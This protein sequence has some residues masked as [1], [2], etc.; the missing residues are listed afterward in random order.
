MVATTQRDSRCPIPFTHRL[1]LLFISVD[2]GVAG[3]AG[4]GVAGAGVAGVHCLQPQTLDWTSREG[5]EGP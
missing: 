2:P 4:A 3:V 5:A 1:K